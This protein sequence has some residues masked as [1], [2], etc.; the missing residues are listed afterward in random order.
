MV[1]T[2]E[3]K[4][5]PSTRRSK[6]KK[7]PVSRIMRKPAFC[8]CENN[9]ADQL[10]SYQPAE[11]RLCFCN[12]DPKSEISSCDCLAGLFCLFALSLFTSTVNS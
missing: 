7:D 10:R 2:N 12:K 11:Q 3:N 5:V 4:I 6:D 9:G 8:I 1:H